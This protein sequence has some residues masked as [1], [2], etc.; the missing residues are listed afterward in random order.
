MKACRS[1]SQ[2]GQPQVPQQQQQHPQ[3]AHTPHSRIL[4]CACSFFDETDFCG[5]GERKCSSVA[6]LSLLVPARCPLPAARC[7][8]LLAFL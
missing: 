5:L 4:G 3:H 1:V 6:L 8:L 7:L 2:G